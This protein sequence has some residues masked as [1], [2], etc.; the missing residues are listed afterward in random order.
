MLQETQVDEAHAQRL[1]KEPLKKPAKRPKAAHSGAAFE[2]YGGIM[3]NYGNYGDG[4]D[5]ALLRV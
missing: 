5:G 3:V 2:N 1:S 4:V